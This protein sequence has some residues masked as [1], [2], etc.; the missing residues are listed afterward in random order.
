MCLAAA[1]A[2][3]I[4][5]QTPAI[6]NAQIDSRPAGDLRA[7]VGSVESKTEPAWV[8]W[9]VPMIPGERQLCSVWSSQTHSVRGHYLE[10]WTG[11]APPPMSTPP[12]PTRL[13]AGTR[14]VIF[15]RVING[16]VER[17]RLSSD[18]CPVDAGGLRVV[19]LE[20]VSEGSSIQYLESLAVDA[21]AP[22]TRSGA[23]ASAVSAI[24]LHDAAAADEAL[25][26]LAVTAGEREVGRQAASWLARARGRRGF[27]T[28]TRLLAATTSPATRRA[29]V[30]ALAQS[31]LPD[32]FDTLATLARTHS[33]ERVR[34]EAV[35]AISR[36][37]D[38]RAKEFLTGVLRQ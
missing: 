30:A 7:V 38:P 13:E 16:T 33:D 6:Q 14:L 36:S 1:V 3:S 8:T 24:A 29:V 5:A 37:T 9:S 31:P 19:R 34:V 18:D 15:A 22:A 20:N 12:G 26:R 28:L 27:D 23:I 17:I 25:E 35:R 11:A 10:G 2:L 32:T 21:A 4:A